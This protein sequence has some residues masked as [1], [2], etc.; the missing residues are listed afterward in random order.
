MK[1]TDKELLD[2]VNNGAYGNVYSNLQSVEWQ[3]NNWTTDIR[4]AIARCIDGD[5]RDKERNK[6]EH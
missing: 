1:Y 5:K 3:L 4:V 2:W 6:D